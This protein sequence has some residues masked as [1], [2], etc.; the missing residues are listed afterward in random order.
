M[1]E[2]VKLPSS[3]P[4]QIT[5]SLF[6]MTHLVHESPARR[7][8]KLMVARIVQAQ[9]ISWQ[10]I[11][12]CILQ[13]KLVEEQ[14]FLL[15]LLGSCER[16][17]DNVTAY[18]H[19][20]LNP[21]QDVLSKAFSRG[22]GTIVPI[23]QAQVIIANKEFK[24]S[25]NSIFS[26][27]NPDAV[28]VCEA[29]LMNSIFDGKL[30]VYNGYLHPDY[31]KSEAKVLAQLRLVAKVVGCSTALQIPL[32][33]NKAVVLGRS[34]SHVDH[35]INEPTGSII[36]RVHAKILPKSG[37]WQII[38]ESKNGIFV[39]NFKVKESELK[40]GDVYVQISL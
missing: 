21:T 32:F 12:H 13:K 28:I 4:I 5:D 29:W 27:R 25:E 9:V 18:L 37:T 38:D 22:A 7:T 15:H 16:L 30:Y 20:G 1:A 6:E 39:N 19:Q 2:F 14:P 8:E 35:V 11:K 40:D 10:W 17:F 26:K 31:V 24:L 3:R 36:S 34:A 33:A 23:E